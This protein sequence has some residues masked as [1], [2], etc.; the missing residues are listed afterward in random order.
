MC[1][2]RLLALLHRTGSIHACHDKRRGNAALLT[3]S[4]HGADAHP[5]AKGSILV[6]GGYGGIS[7]TYV[8]MNDMFVLDTIR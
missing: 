4:A 5:C 8:W 2:A 1:M 7:S 3:R 6:M